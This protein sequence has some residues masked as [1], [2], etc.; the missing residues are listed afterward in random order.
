M[1]EERNRRSSRISRR[2]RTYIE[3]EDETK[4]SKMENE[5]KEEE[6]VDT[7]EK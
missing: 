5:K 3:V 7:K 1:E 2:S 6:E 4:M